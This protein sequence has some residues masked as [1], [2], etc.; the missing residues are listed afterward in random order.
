MKTLSMVQFIKER[1]ND[2]WGGDLLDDD[3]REPI[4]KHL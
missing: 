1:V 3:Q 2:F 4:V